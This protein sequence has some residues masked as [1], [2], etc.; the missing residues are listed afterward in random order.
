MQTEGQ[1]NAYREWREMS[2]DKMAALNPSFEV[3]EMEKMQPDV[4]EIGDKKGHGMM[5]S[6]IS[7]LY[8]HSGM[9]MHF[10]CI[11]WTLLISN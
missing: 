8:E 3:T 10:C 7:Y 2:R 5:L 1:S 4:K 6:V 9:H 11:A